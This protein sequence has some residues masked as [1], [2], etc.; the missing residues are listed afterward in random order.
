MQGDFSRDS[1]DPSKQFTRVL[2]QQGR[3]LVDADWNEQTAILLNYL[4]ALTA[5]FIG[6]HGGPDVLPGAGKAYPATSGAFEISLDSSNVKVTVKA[7]RYYV[8]GLL[9]EVPEK[10]ADYEAIDLNRASELKTRI[11]LVEAWERHVSAVSDTAASHFNILDPALGGLDTATRTRLMVR[12][13]VLF[14][15]ILISDIGLKKSEDFRKLKKQQKTAPATLPALDPLIDSR[16]LNAKNLLPHMTAWTTIASDRNTETC[17]PASTIGYTGLENQLYRVE[18]HRGG[19]TLWDGVRSSDGRAGPEDP[20]GPPRIDPD[21]LPVT[22]KWSRDN[23]SVVY[24]VAT[25]SRSDSG[26]LTLAAVWKDETKAIKAGHWIEI[27]SVESDADTGVLAKVV[28]VN[29]RN[30]GVEVAFTTDD[31]LG[32]PDAAKDPVIV[33]RWDHHARKDYPLDG[34]AILVEQKS[35]AAAE[36]RTSGEIPLEDGISIR[37]DLPKGGEFRPGDYWLI[38]A[39]A[40]VGDILWPIVDRANRGEAR[41]DALPARYAERHY[42][43]LAFIDSANAI[44]DLRRTINPAAH[45]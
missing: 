10:D 45:E 9:L 25:L 7:G 14:T 36:A 11:V 5:D 40:A 34:G 32:L 30:T 19:E 39:R 42:A 6:W 26:S 35:S 18:I 21:K 31:P 15:G 8:D 33:R 28:N 4:R 20:N 23:G 44:T 16:P 43:P 22:V 27:L 3:L 38:P 24:P 12:F 29:M 2:L 41:Y 13:R 1:F 37:F 17:D